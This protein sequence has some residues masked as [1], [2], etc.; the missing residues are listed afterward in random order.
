MTIRYALAFVFVMLGH[1]LHA[2]TWLTTPVGATSAT[3]GEVK[4][5]K[6]GKI[7]LFRHL[8]KSKG[9]AHITERPGQSLHKQ[10]AHRTRHR[11]KKEARVFHRQNHF[12]RKESP[13][14]TRSRSSKR[15]PMPKH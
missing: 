8:K 12:A 4:I 11:S 7:S 14:R 6:T 1:V 10:K 3:D 5:H 2:Q 9:Q 13:S 15:G